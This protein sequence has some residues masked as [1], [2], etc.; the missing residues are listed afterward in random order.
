MAIKLTREC[1]IERAR[2]IHKDKYGYERVVYTNT[3]TKVCIVCPTHG[4]FF[5][6]PKA[7][8][9]SKQGC[10]RCYG[11]ARQ[12]T[13]GFIN[14]AKLVHGDKYDYS[15]VTYVSN[16]TKVDIK[17]YTHGIFQVLPRNHTTRSSGCPHCAGRARL[18][19]DVFISK[20]KSIHGDKYDYSEV[21]YVNS[22]TPVKIICLTHGA[23]MQKPTIH[24]LGQC[25]CPRCSFSK[26][27]AAIERFLLVNNVSYLSQYVPPDLTNKSKKAHYRFDFFLPMH[28]LLIE[29]DGVQHDKPV[30]Y[31][32]TKFTSYEKIQERDQVK[33]QYSAANNIRLIRVKYKDLNNINQILERELQLS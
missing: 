1:F 14:Q 24:T 31:W 33:N 6:T 17:C 10:P 22:Q 9:I 18:S 28:N 30:E 7:H 11:N 12:N 23:F 21:S 13:S 2:R 3:N 20:A 16:D 26:G 25:G 4:N 5:Q 8:T 27:E 15:Q 32:N 19:T 29:F